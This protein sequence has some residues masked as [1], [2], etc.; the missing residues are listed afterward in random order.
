MAFAAAQLVALADLAYWSFVDDLPCDQRLLHL[1]PGPAFVKSRM[2]DL[3]TGYQ[4]DLVL[5][6]DAGDHWC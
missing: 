4:A 1:T 3:P 2:A 5:M 6:L